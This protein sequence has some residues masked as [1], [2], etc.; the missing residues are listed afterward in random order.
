MM[1]VSKCYHLFSIEYYYASPNIVSV[2]INIREKD[3]LLLQTFTHFSI[4]VGDFICASQ[5]KKAGKL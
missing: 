3:N 4:L 5:F 1:P 2:F